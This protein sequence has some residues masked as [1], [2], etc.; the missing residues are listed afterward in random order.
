MSSS[1]PEYGQATGALTRAAGLVSDA[2]A[3]FNSI[4]AKLT[5]QINGVQSQ[6]GGQGATAFFVLHQAW[7]EKQRTIVS[8]LDEFANSLTSTEKDNTNTDEAQHSTFNKLNSRL[9]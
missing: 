7:S 8:A 1:N 6:W 2:K 5:D 4:S 3:D 9:S